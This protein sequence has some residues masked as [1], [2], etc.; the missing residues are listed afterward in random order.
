MRIGDEER[1]EEMISK[2]EERFSRDEREWERDEEIK[3]FDIE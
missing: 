1:N 3:I 2:R